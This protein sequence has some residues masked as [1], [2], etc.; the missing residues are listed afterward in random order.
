MAADLGL[1]YLLHRKKHH[2]LERLVPLILIS[3]GT[4]GAIHNARELRRAD[5]GP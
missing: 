1:R 5:K 4:V 2:R 3:Y